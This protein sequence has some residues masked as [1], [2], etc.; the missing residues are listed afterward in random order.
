MPAES[1]PEEGPDAPAQPREP[2]AEEGPDAP[3]PPREP[4][5]EERRPETPEQ[6][7]EPPERRETPGERL[8]RQWNEL[9]QELRVTQ[10]GIQL[11]GGFLLVM[12][13]Q[14]RFGDLGDE[15]LAVYLTAVVAAT[16]STFF[17]LAPVAL[18][19][20]LFQSHRKDVLV[21]VGDRLAR[22][23]LALLAVTVI[24]VSALVF[25]FLLD[26]LAALIAGLGAAV[27]CVGLWWV[28]PAWLRRKPAS[29]VYSF[30]PAGDEDA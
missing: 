18:H 14:Q 4:P 28:L 6:P 29:T 16:G 13:F 11:L 15:L 30:G 7:R 24:C 19:R 26:D 25:G 17:V 27:V 5:A 2:L 10:T 8:D 9:L 3:A 1:P 23:G 20:A 12:P 22:I 21:R